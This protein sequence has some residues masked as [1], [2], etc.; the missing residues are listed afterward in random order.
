MNRSPVHAMTGFEHRAGD[1]SRGNASQT[2]LGQ[3][4]GLLFVSHR[5]AR[6][7]RQGHEQ[8]LINQMA[9]KRNVIVS[10]VFRAIVCIVLLAGSLFVFWRL[11]DTAPKPPAADISNTLPRV[12]VMQAHPV[13]VQRQWEGYGAAHAMESANVPSRVTSTVIARPDEIR[14]G[15]SVTKGQMLVKLDDS[16]FV[17]QVEIA[18]QSMQD[19]EAQLNRLDVEER[20]WS[21]R[22]DLVA[23]DARLARADLQ[24]VQDAMARGGAMQR[25]LDQAKQALNAAE[26]SEVATREELEKI[27]PRRASL[28]AQLLQE[29]ATARLASQNVE[30]SQIASPID[31][32][33]QAVDVEVGESITAGE[34]VA[35]VVSLNRIEVPLVLSAGA[36]QHISVGDNAMLSSEN[37]KRVTWAGR[38]ARIAP[39]DDQST[40]TM[41]VYVEVEVQPGAAPPVPPAPGQFV[42]G[43]VIS[44]HAEA[45]WVVPR[46]AIDRDRLRLVVENQIVSRAVETDFA[47]EGELPAFDLPDRQWTVLKS[48]LPA[49]A[50]VVVDSSRNFAEGSRVE[51][52][53][54]NT[55]DAQIA[56]G[57]HDE[58]ANS[59]PKDASP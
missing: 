47:L 27:V 26:Q 43:H 53:I 3:T 15:R 16:D 40:R 32:I 54:V 5:E 45:R 13:P 18:T 11:K 50:L 39:E 36:R 28:R 1:L 25:E 7:P 17:R 29:Q 30:R 37:G 42:R 34:R 22:A 21:A 24:R 59:P 31:G 20:S 4:D 57:H 14:P 19:I 9:A 38:V 33:L 41:R 35:R 23:E 52:V 2:R 51:P 10:V 12:I 44:S 56:A 55:A 6:L 58:S 46:R 8:R 49:D 48:S